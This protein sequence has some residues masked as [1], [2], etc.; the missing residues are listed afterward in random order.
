[1]YIQ[2]S[3]LISAAG[4]SPGGK[5]VDEICVT[6]E[7][8]KYFCFVFLFL[9][10]R[11]FATGLAVSPPPVCVSWS[12]CPCTRALEVDTCKRTCS[13]CC[14]GEYFGGVLLYSTHSLSFQHTTHTGHPDG[15]KWTETGFWGL[16]F[17]FIVLFKSKQQK[18]QHKNSL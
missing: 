5:T 7:D 1:M 10:F 11:L 13:I 18:K 9:V 2:T 17:V 3:A 12:V 6:R 8:L 4:K 15:F 16:G 14:F